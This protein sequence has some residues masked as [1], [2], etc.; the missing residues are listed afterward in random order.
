MTDRTALARL[1]LTALAEGRTDD[2]RHLANKALAPDE[3]NVG[4]YTAP[5]L[6]F[7][8]DFCAYRGASPKTWE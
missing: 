8:L 5:V 1:A 6:S 2:A 7:L 3:S 4:P